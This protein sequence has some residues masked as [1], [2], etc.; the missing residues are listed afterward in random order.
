VSQHSSIFSYVE[1]KEESGITYSNKRARKEEHGH[2][3]DSDHGRTILL[4]FARQVGRQCRNRFTS[5]TFGLVGKV[6]QLH[7]FIK[8]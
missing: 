8:G 5:T 4:G 1:R 6:E 2:G 3:G 7:E